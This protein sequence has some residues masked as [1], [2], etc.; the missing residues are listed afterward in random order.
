M[1]F[2]R[3]P[4]G[5]LPM[6]VIVMDVSLHGTQ[7]RSNKRLLPA[8]PRATRASGRQSR[9][10]FDRELSLVNRLFRFGGVVR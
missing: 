4:G 2:N 6:D 1:G 7:V 8:Q 5:T 10:A 3:N 9:M